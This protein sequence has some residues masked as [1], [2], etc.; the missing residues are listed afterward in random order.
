[1]KVIQLQRGNDEL[2]NKGQGY[3]LVVDLDYI[4]ENIYK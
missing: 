1:M 4:D 2:R 3:F